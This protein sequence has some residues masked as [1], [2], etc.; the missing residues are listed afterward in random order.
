MGGLIVEKVSW[1][2]IFWIISVAHAALQ[3]FGLFFHYESYGPKILADKVQYLISKTGNQY[4]H[5]QWTSPRASILSTLWLNIKRP[6]V[7]LTTQPAIQA[8]GLYRAYFYGVKYL[9]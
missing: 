2:F 3:I 6:F 8:L 4:L 9:M 7:M 1:R 5:T